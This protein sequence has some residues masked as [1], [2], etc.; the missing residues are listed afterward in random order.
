MKKLPLIFRNSWEEKADEISGLCR[1]FHTIIADSITIENNEFP[2]ILKRL[3]SHARRFEMDGVVVCHKSFKSAL[4][5]FSVLEKLV[6]AD[7][8]V[9]EEVKVAASTLKSLKTLVM[10]SSD[11]KF[12][13]YFCESNTQVRE[14]K[15]ASRS[16]NEVDQYVFEAFL[17]KQTELETLAIRVNDGAIYRSLAKFKVK[18][19]KFKLKKLSVDFKF[20]GSDSSIDDAFIDF[21]GH[22][23]STLEDLET[24]KNLSEPILEFIMKRMKIKR[25]IIDA[26]RL[27]E[28]PLFYN[29][30][31]PNQH[32]ETLHV[33]GTLNK[34][35]VARGLLCIYPAIKQLT[36]TEWD[37]EVI[38]DTLIYMANNLK[39]LQILEVPTL[40]FDTPEL[41]I[42]TLKTLY[43]DFVDDVTQWQTF[44]MNNPS[45]ETLIV[46]WMTNR[47]T[48]TYEIID[49]ITTRLQN[50]KHV[51][52]GAYFRPTARILNM[53]SRNC[54]SLRL[55]ELF[56]D[57]PEEL[58]RNASIGHINVIYYPH[59]AVLA[60]FKEIPTIW[61]DDNNYGSESIDDSEQSD[62]DMDWDDDDITDDENDNDWDFDGDADGDGIFFFY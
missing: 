6:I 25:L 52:F 38:N 27:P 56:E 11:W 18:K 4:S 21:L 10:V 22:H 5:S 53:M 8:R 54:P 60:V 58:Q 62:E 30:I 49:A 61:M 20:W 16:F 36:V 51:K 34:Y 40:T 47:N 7:S 3:A 41:P 42:P 17:S 45:I 26:S 50:L 23:E 24:D 28:S 29:T 1:N 31:R 44:L 32:L 9:T 37:R 48:F 33:K 57:N 19:Y 12:L 2:V 14:L 55:L 43:V 35:D 46:K 13:E 59:E 15:I 39:N